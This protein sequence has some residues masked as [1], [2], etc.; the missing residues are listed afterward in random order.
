MIG[1]SA[2]FHH[3]GQQLARLTIGD[4][5]SVVHRIKSIVSS[6]ARSS[7]PRTDA[8]TGGDTFV[9]RHRQRVA[10]IRGSDSTINSWGAS[11]AGTDFESA[12]IP[13]KFLATDSRM[14]RAQLPARFFHP[15]STNSGNGRQ[16]VPAD[17]T[18]DR[19]RCPAVKSLRSHPGE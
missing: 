4:F 6:C 18:A 1:F 3:S 12:G 8:R 14:R 5:F 10:T 7:A 13:M 19:T 9:R 2:L 11:L 16:T 15:H 17:T